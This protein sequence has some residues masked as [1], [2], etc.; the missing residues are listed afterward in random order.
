MVQDDR[1]DGG[2]T[3]QHCLS[4]RHPTAHNTLCNERLLLVYAFLGKDFY[5]LLALKIIESGRSELP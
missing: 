2:I 1:V 3:A 4:F 5:A